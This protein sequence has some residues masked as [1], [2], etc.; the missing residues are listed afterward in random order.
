M[1]CIFDPSEE[2]TNGTKLAR[3]LVD[4]G[5]QALRKVLESFIHPSSTLQILLNSN[6]ATLNNLKT[7]GKI[8]DSQ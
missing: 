2:K 8:Y 6:W 7:R 5:T 4:G 1:S 3:L